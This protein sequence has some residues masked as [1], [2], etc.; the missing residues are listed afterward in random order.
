MDYKKKILSFQSY[1]HRLTI[2]IY[3][4]RLNKIHQA[5]KYLV[6]NSPL[7]LCL[8]DSQNH[9]YR[10]CLEF[11]WGP[12]FCSLKFTCIAFVWY[13]L[14]KKRSIIIMPLPPDVTGDTF[15]KLIITFYSP[16]RITPVNPLHLVKFFTA[17]YFT[18]LS[19]W[20]KSPKKKKE[21]YF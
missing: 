14:L 17:Y 4:N 2:L 11:Y 9:F 21:G 3:C 10:T 1:Y 6:V 15:K 5:K 20:A 18:N 12:S 7:F 8:C 13:E 19:F 16:W